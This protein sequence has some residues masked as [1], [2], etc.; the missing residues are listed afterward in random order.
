[1]YKKNGKLEDS[2]IVRASVKGISAVELDI[3]RKFLA[4]VFLAGG[5]GAVVTF[6][7]FQWLGKKWM[8]DRFAK[9]LEDYRHQQ[10]LEL[11]HFKQRVNALFK[12]ITKIHEKEFDVLP[13][14]WQK[15]IDAKSHVSSLVSIL[16]EYPDLENMSPSHLNEFLENSKLSQYHKEEIMETANKN[17]TYQNI[18]YWYK[19]EDAHKSIAELH[20]YLIYNK[21]FL[22]SHLF[23]K[24]SEVDNL[25][26]SALLH[27]RTATEIQEFKSLSKPYK[28]VKEKAEPLIEDIEKLV[29]KRLHYQDAE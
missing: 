19:L 9:G 28:D 13:I 5:A 15:L 26:Y 27:H 3:I 6:G 24:V 21:I 8:E 29:Q 22:S 1:L 12:R 20:N 23:M 7:L 17:K 16:Q 11:E 4:D 25:L 10:N 14:A 2:F 18:I